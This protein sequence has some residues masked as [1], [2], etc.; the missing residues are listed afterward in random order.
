[1]VARNHENAREE[2]NKYHL[3]PYP[4]RP[5]IP[6]RVFNGALDLLLD[7]VQFSA[8]GQEEEEN[9]NSN[10]AHDRKTVRNRRK[11]GHFRIT[12]I[13]TPREEHFGDTHDRNGIRNN[14]DQQYNVTRQR[15]FNRN[16]QFVTDEDCGKALFAHNGVPISQKKVARRAK[17]VYKSRTYVSAHIML[18]AKEFCSLVADG[19][20]FPTEETT[21]R[22]LPHALHKEKEC[23]AIESGDLKG[24]FGVGDGGMGP[25]SRT[26]HGR[27]QIMPSRYNDS[28]LQPWKRGTR[29]KKLAQ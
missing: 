19:G 23:K 24:D 11:D 5:V 22:K 29:P 18:P 12:D 20:S 26:K 25:V 14:Q 2:I 27:S 1:M 28:V 10:N 21:G 16:P 8:F 6:K 13:K 9:G 17:N 7:A 4:A 15:G 3:K